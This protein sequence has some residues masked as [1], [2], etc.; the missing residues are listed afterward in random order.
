[1]NQNMANVPMAYAGTATL[2][3]GNLISNV[4]NAQLIS[5]IRNT[6]RRSKVT[7]TGDVGAAVS[8][9]ITG[10][11][12]QV[13]PPEAIAAAQERGRTRD[14][15]ETAKELLAEMESEAD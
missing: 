12:A 11:A 15:W 7:L 1:M 5:R 9:I 14:L 2:H 4:R 10:V 13:L 8:T 6:K 3:F